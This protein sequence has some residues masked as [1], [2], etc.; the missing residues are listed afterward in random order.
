MKIDSDTFVCM[1]CLAAFIGYTL[2]VRNMVNT[3]V[4]TQQCHKVT[5]TNLSDLADILTSS[6]LMI[7]NLQKNST[8]MQVQSPMLILEDVH[9]VHDVVVSTAEEDKVDSIE[10]SASSEASS[11]IHTNNKT[12]LSPIILNNSEEEYEVILGN[13]KKND[14]TK[15]IKTQ[16]YFGWFDSIF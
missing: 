5:Q 11:D 2:G 1:I 7:N 16:Y 6:H 12:L 14:T 3:T 15:G 4:K 13:V 8:I 9:D 10:T